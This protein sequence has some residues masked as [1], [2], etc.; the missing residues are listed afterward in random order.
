M[1]GRSRSPFY[2][3]VGRY[4]EPR[5]IRANPRQEPLV[6]EIAPALEKELLNYPGKW[7]AVTRSELISFGDDLGIVLGEAHARGFESPIVWHVPEP[8][9]FYAFEAEQS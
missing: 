2:G 5:V 6:H 7:V 3:S 9:V 1:R 8:G 4:G